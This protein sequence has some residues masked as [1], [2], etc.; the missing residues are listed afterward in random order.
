MSP[1]VLR[2]RGFRFFFFSR[3]EPRKHVHVQCGHGEAK[4]WLRPEVELARNEGL[5][6][7]DL[8]IVEDLIREYREDIERAWNEHFGG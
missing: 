6:K 1:T 3:E 8:G 5:R 2:K 4:F 7:K